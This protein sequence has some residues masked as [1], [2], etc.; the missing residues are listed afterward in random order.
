MR[1]VIASGMIVAA[2][3]LMGADVKETE[4][5]PVQFEP[6]PRVAAEG[7]SPKITV[8][9]QHG[10]Y[11][12]YSARSAK[13]GMD[14]WVQASQDV[15]D[16]FAEPM[17]VNDVEGEVS[18]HGENSAQ[19][20]LS[21]DENTLYAVWNGKDASVGGGSHVRFAR[22]GTMMPGW[23][24]AVTVNDD[25]LPVSHGFQG[26][27]VGP[28][29]TIFVAWLDGRERESGRGMEGTSALY[30][31]RSRDGG[32]TWEKNVRVAGDVCPCCR[33][34][35]GFSGGN[36]VVFWR[37]VEADQTRDIYSAASA[38]GGATWSEARLVARDGWKING[39]PHVGAAVAS[40]GERLWAAWFS[41]AA[42]DPAIYAAWTGDGGRTFSGRIRISEGVT[43]PTH[44]AMAGDGERLAVV[45]QARDANA[46]AGWGRMGVYY[47]EIG[48][49]GLSGLQRLGEGK[50][51]ASYPFVA[52]GLSGRVFTAWTEIVAGNPRAML[53]RGRRR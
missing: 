40:L 12:L 25:R 29:G 34:A 37:G 18:D 41:E 28:D 4:K 11:L 33:A 6:S 39:C 27:A 48:A 20:L 26:A 53:L 38:D 43:D 45:F 7:R 22:G 51:N 23:S 8:R 47:R 3:L 52:H 19:L 30:L 1:N 9:R 44:P 36:V 5:A 21:P 15:G 14:L 31:S 50:A 42:G 13:G 17:R 16:T 24:K 32:Q 46:E 49:D 35:I 10:L 2:A